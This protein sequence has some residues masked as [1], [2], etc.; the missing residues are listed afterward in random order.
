L[1]AGGNFI[2]LAAAFVLALA[3]ES[4]IKSLVSSF[5]TPVLGIIGSRNFNDLDFTVRGSRFA[6]GEFINA[7]ISFLTIGMVIFF[8][9]ILPVQ[10]YGG[11]CAPAWVQTFCEYCCQQIPAIATKCPHCCSAVTPVPVHVGRQKG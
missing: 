11:K 8:C 1:P 3:L 6:Y 5:I 9:L 4:L 10:R 7:A 2:R